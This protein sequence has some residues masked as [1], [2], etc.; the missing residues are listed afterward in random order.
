MTLF[1]MGL[2]I[3]LVI[4]QMAAVYLAVKKV[5]HKLICSILVIICSGS[6]AELLFH[7]E[8][9]SLT[10]LFGVSR[11]EDILL[12]IGIP[13]LFLLYAALYIRLVIINR[14]FLELV[15]KIALAE[16]SGRQ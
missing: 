16:V 11:N 13:L 7:K 9:D 14:K 12:Y 6:M 10:T 2:M 8:L 3:I 4:V 5:L 15:R 1:I